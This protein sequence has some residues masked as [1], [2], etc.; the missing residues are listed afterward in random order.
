MEKQETTNESK[1]F[2][3]LKEKISGKAGKKEKHHKEKKPTDEEVIAELTETLQRLQAEFENYRKRI[4]KEKE[5][6]VKYAKAELVY[7]LLPT[8]DAFEVALKNTNGGEKFIK[9]MEMVYAQLFSALQSEG[10]KPI[11]A[12]GKKFDP[13]MHEVMLKQKS[14]KEDGI[15][16]EELQK[17]YT[18]NG[19]VLRHSKVKVSEN[20]EE[21]NKEKET[22]DGKDH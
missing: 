1:G 4:D 19:R 5:E 6:F 8:L 12:F 22:S 3:K 2:E 10:L 9:G 13:Y 20:S 7:R 14:D 21:E 17:G 16:L 18:L 15:I 11:E